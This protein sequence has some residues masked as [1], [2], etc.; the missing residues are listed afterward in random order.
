[1]G[2]ENETELT[3][4]VPAMDGSVLTTT[5]ADTILVE[6]GAVELSL[7]KLRSECSILEK[8]LGCI[9]RVPKL[10]GSCGHGNESKIVGLLGPLDVT[11]WVSSG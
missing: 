4:L 7:R 2:F 5:V 9:S 6:H 1:M 10:N 8:L 11:N 3:S